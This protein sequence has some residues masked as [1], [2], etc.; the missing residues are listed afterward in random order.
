[1]PLPLPNLDDRRFDDLT[2]E[3]QAR[4]LR[5]VPEL[6]RIVPGDPVHTLVD[7][8]AWLAETV[9]YRA[10]RIPER[11]Q[12]AFLNLL[13]IP[14][15]PALP[16]RGIV[17]ID[18]VGSDSCLPPLL[19]SESPL[20]AGQISFITVGELQATPLELRV[21]VKKSLDTKVLTAEGITLEQ[22]RH[23]YGVE[24]AAFRPE[25]LT[26]GQKPL[27]T[28]GTADGA[29]YL[30]CALQ[31]PQLI[32]LR[33]KLLRQL[34]GCVLNFG[35]APQ[36][37]ID[38]DIA[39]NLAPRRLQWDL[40]WWPDAAAPDEVTY[41]PLEVVDDSSL[42]G[43]RC[44][45]A[46]V[47][48]PGS[49]EMLTLPEVSDP[50]FAGFKESPPEPPADLTSGRLLFWLRLRCVEDDLELGYLG[51]N[52]VDILGLGSA[53]DLMVG[54]G[55]GRPDQSLNLPHTDIDATGLR[56]EVEELRRFVPWRLVSHFAG[57]GPDDPVYTLDQSS[58]TIRFGD[59]I[60]GR[61][62]PATARIRAACYRYGGGSSGNLP[63]GSIN[64]IDG[65]AGRLKLRHEWPTSG[66]TDRE[67]IARAERRIP[68]FLGHRDRAVTG[69]DFAQLALDNPV[70]PVARADAV[71]GFFPGASLTA[72]RRAI[73]GVISLFVL[74][75]ALP[76]IGT[77]PRPTAGMIREL[78]D[79]LSVRTL[80]GTELYVL[81]PQ[82]QPVA[83]AISLEVSDP[84][85]EQQTF[86][87]V[88]EALLQYLWPLSPHGLRGA[89]WP[90]G[91]SVEKNELRTRAGRVEGV[92]AV[93][94]LHLFYQDLDSREWRELTA[95][96]ALTL[97][98]YQLP[99]LME[100]ALQPGEG[101]P[102]PPRSFAPGSTGTTTVSGG[103]RAV[104][105]PVI[106]DIC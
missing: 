11:Q 75:P 82:Y 13:Q 17:C 20:T 72:V 81:S 29:L 18:A 5:Q 106:P 42:G 54:S 61:R 83:I 65:G 34:A 92:E 33:D 97:R 77:A 27:T 89:G 64:R 53:R 62:P 93:N 91:R 12:R 85:T 88:E 19:R 52:A 51:V 40:A 32:P 15:R 22:L 10:N 3:L 7:L 79:Y 58:G 50:Q 76:V 68:A 35:L 94:V 39:A 41:L 9:I 6:T 56:I 30:A 60:T 87:A 67:S 23:Q 59:G 45:V 44:G 38:G 74:P 70:R 73:P 90:L 36:T 47:R 63:A 16:A 99:Q 8:F 43:R 69:E 28:A 66:G 105:V 86:R 102:A 96:Q 80:L 14:L 46:R 104:P 24:P 25:T 31:K 49:V 57:S 84:A 37:E 1:M 21:L 55:T 71:P 98:D 4:L 48:L 78:Y 101:E 100:V 103:T 95:A 26:P 2:A